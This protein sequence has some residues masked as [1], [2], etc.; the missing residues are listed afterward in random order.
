MKTF[1]LLL[2]FFIF[3]TL[4]AEWTIVDII[5]PQG[6][7]TGYLYGLDYHDGYLWVGDDYEGWIHQVD[8]ANGSV[9]SSF[10]GAP[11]SN[12]GLTWDGEYFWVAGD[13]HADG[14]IYKMTADGT[15]VATIPNPG[16]DYSGGLCWH[17]G[18]LWASVYYPNTQPNIHKLDP[19]DGTILES[20]STVGLQ[21]QGLVFQDESTFWN[22]MDDNDGDPERC[23]AY[24]PATGDTL[25]SFPVPTTKPRGLA[26]DGEYLYLVAKEDGSWDQVIYKIDLSGS[27]TPEI[28]VGISF[29]NFGNT[30]IAQEATHDIAITNNGTA[31]LEIAGID[32]TAPEFSCDLQFPFLINPG[33]SEYVTV[34]FQPGNWGPYE[35]VMSISSNDPINPEVTVDLQ[36]YGIFAEQAL[37]VS[38]D[39]LDYGTVRNGATVGKYLSISNQ[40]AEELIIDDI[41]IS[42][43][44]FYLDNTVMLP[45]ILGT[46]EIRDLR[47][48]FHPQTPGDYLV[49]MNIYSNDPDQN[50]YVVQLAGF[51]ED[52]E[53]PIGTI[54]WEYL[55]DTSWDNSPKAITSCED[56]NG[57]EVEDVIVCSEDNY[58]RCFNGNSSGS[59]DVLWETEVYSGNVYSQ[60]GLTVIQDIDGDSY[61]DI[62]IATTGG[63]RSIRALSGLT[64]A[65]IWQHDTSEYGNGGWVYQVFAKLDY[66]GDQVQDVLAATGDD[67]ADTGPKRIYCLDGLTGDTIWSYYVGGPA[68]AVIGIDDITADGNPDV[69]AGASN[70]SET[71]GKV[72]AINGV[73]GLAEWNYITPG[74]SVWGL[75]QIADVSGDGINDIAAGDFYGNY[76]GLNAVTGGFLYSGSIGAY[77]L[78]TRFEPLEDITGDDHP[79][80]L[81]ENSGNYAVTVDGFT[82]N[83]AWNTYIGDNSLS[84]SAIP[85]INADNVNDVLI[86]SLNNSSYF[87]DGATGTQMYSNA[88]GTP[89]DAIKSI[90]DI[91]GDNS[92]E[93]VIGGRNGMVRCIS[94]GTEVMVANGDYEMDKITSPLILL[95]NYPNP[96]FPV[97]GYRDSGTTI[98]YI[99]LQEQIIDLAIYNLK[100][101]KVRKILNDQFQVT[102]EH[103]AY[104]DGKNDRGN[105]MP[106]GIYLYKL[107]TAKYTNI[108][109][110][111][112]LN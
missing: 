97:S 49:D 23:T 5:V 27:G 26:W 47:V 101:Q 25:W 9:L 96:F 34:T 90:P 80:I 18:Y 78:I 12:H 54:L 82:G 33:T 40:G 39:Y 31:D 58:V 109:K 106:A 6:V 62:I 53:Y 55:I 91:T 68:F 75:M 4:E 79:D 104:W 93:M 57:D 83:I 88:H 13:Y 22:S 36:G 43:A 46:V 69:L 29:Y 15:V 73:T 19:A 72:I 89:V 66:N 107:S 64:G 14:N 71:E 84:V 59:G 2:I 110:M 11:E 92:W 86:G 60:K 21:P 77:T 105:P 37:I 94:G 63:D 28:N 108:K 20:M 102:G 81:I 74:S 17:D 35:A 67:S 38:T 44:S 99:L 100:G 7:E 85:D 24:D 41:A 48:W 95:G 61:A 111:L 16:D 32:F 52:T 56:I 98:Q 103:T 87:L 76:F 1:A 112:L 45:I 30:I 65:F 42:D 3:L 51:A 10:Q 8:P 70:E 50:P